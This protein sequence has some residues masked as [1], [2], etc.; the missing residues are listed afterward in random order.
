MIVKSF[1]TNK[2]N[3]NLN[4]LFLFYGKN[5]GFKNEATKNILKKKKMYLIMK[6][7]KS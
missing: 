7:R 3:L 1:E 2:I 6:K 5:E 4:N